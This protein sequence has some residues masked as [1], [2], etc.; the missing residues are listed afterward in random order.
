MGYTSKPCPGCGEVSRRRAAAKVCPD[1]QQL[2]KDGEI[3]RSILK[4][5]SQFDL[6]YVPE[7]HRPHDYP[8]LYRAGDKGTEF[9]RA[10]SALVHLLGK[11][12]KTG[13][14]HDLPDLVPHPPMSDN[15][16][17]YGVVMALPKGSA[18]LLGKIYE[19]VRLMLLDAYKEGKDEGTDLLNQLAKGE[20]SADEFN[21]QS[22][23]QG[24]AGE[25]DK[26]EMLKIIQNHKLPQRVRDA[27][28][29]LYDLHRG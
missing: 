19:T 26:A 5:E 11:P 6:V 17:S 3:Y 10:F 18:P 27:A 23:E 21:E 1:C 7:A 14:R 25:E 4:A 20:L 9:C 15:H 28:S 13:S 2:M 22:I 12:H 16:L 29:R 24:S 8:Y